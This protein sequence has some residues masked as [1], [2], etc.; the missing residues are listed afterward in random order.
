MGGF[1]LN[2]DEINELELELIST[3]ISKMNQ[4]RDAIFW[5]KDGINIEGGKRIRLNKK[6]AFFGTFTWESELPYNKV[7]FDMA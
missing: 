4:I 5:G 7:F 6:C 1:W 2:L 3:V